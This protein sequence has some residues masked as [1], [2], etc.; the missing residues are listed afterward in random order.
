MDGWTDG[1]IYGRTDIWM[2]VHMDGRIYGRT[3]PLIEMR[4][5]I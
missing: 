2:D 1:H 5:R 3:D 4:R